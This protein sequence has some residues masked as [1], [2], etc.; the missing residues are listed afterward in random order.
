MAEVKVKVTAQNEVRTGLQQALAETRQFGQEATKSMR[1][2]LNLGEEGLEPLRKIQQELRDIQAQASKPID[3][4]SL[5]GG[6]GATLTASESRR[7]ST[8]V[9]GLAADL[10]AA[11]TPAQAFEAVLTRIGQ[12]AGSLT[13]VVVGLAIGKIIAGQIDQITAAITAFGARLPS[14]QND[15]KNLGTADN[16]DGAI[17]GF[18]RLN[19]VAAETAKTAKELR[20]NPLT[21]AANALSRGLTGNDGIAF[22]EEQAQEIRNAAA[23]NLRVSAGGQL[24]AAQERLP[25][26]G[27][28]TAEAAL[29]QQIKREEEINTLIQEREKARERGE[30]KVVD[31]LNRAIQLTRQRFNVEDQIAAKIKEQAEQAR[32]RSFEA[33]AITQQRTNE[34][35][36]RSLE[37]QLAREQQGLADLEQFSGGGIELRRQQTIARILELEKQITSE[38]EKQAA[39]ELAT[40]QQTA[41]VSRSIQD[42]GADPATLLARAQERLALLENPNIAANIGLSANQ[43]ELERKQLL[44]E[45]LGIEQQIEQAQKRDAQTL[46]G[47]ERSVQT[48]D[49]RRAALE[50]EQAALAEQAAS[51]APD[52]FAGRAEVA[53]EA[54]R[55]AG[56]LRG[57]GQGG[58]QTG[59]F[60]ASS[61]QRI[62]FASDEFFDTRTKK[63]PAD[64]T[65][66]AA[67]FVKQIIDILKK[68]EPLVLSSSN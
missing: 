24:R 33:S 26:V 61:L 51:L 10:A 4:G 67:D 45:I 57:L 16:F 68:G 9:R 66:R 22:L 32:E 49:E 29:V 21:A 63:D 54:Q 28:K 5:D 43:A 65:R 20:S 13:S 36:G 59:S 3:V 18:R 58:G 12:V 25:I 34:N 40:R 1:V 52:D 55:I 2:P 30:N 6:G 17:A 31:S 19:E 7:A 38:R 37:E 23:Q 62:G 42:F 50:D 47:L 41:G 8:A 11:S 27:D 53:A 15:L 44:L 48:P 35:Q 64:E 46:A 39:Q 60:G 14:I 56:E